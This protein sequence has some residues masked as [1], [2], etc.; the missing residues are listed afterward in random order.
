[1]FRRNAANFKRRGDY[2][3]RPTASATA[4]PVAP[5]RNAIVSN[6]MANTQ[7]ASLNQQPQVR[8]PSGPPA[9]WQTVGSQNNRVFDQADQ[10]ATP[11]GA[12]SF[13]RQ[14]VTPTSQPADYS[15]ARPVS[16]GWYAKRRDQAQATLGAPAAAD[17]QSPA[18]SAAANDPIPPIPPQSV[19]RG[20]IEA[21]P[22]VPPKSQT[23]AQA[24]TAGAGRVLL[25]WTRP[26]EP[27]TSAAGE[28]TGVAV[29]DRATLLR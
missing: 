12:A 23:A 9:S 25:E 6:T 18:A 20:P 21:Q 24:Q 5:P 10:F 3:L 29:N 22:L 14:A 7:M 15:S 11:P 16:E 2:I 19:R 28:V 8:I 27:S 17:A 1:M 13:V 4:R 26:D